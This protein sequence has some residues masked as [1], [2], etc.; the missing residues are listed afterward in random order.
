M[1]ATNP[2]PREGPARTSAPP[3]RPPSAPS[4]PPAEGSGLVTVLARPQFTLLVFGQTISQLGDKLHQMALI[5]LVG[6]EA[7]VKTSGFAYGQLA[8]V[9]V[10]LPMLFG[11]VAGALVDRWNKRITMIACDVLRVLI[12]ALIPWL[13]RQSGHLWPVYI[14]AFFVFLSGVF[15]NS[16]KMALIPDLVRRDQLLSANAA[17]TSIGRFATVA[18]LVGGGVIIGWTIWQRVG[19]TGYEAGF[20]MD[21]ISYAVSVISL[22]LITLISAAH[23][24][25]EARH[26]TTSETAV[27]VKREFQH[28][29]GDVR[30]TWKLIRTHHDLRFVFATVVLLGALAASIYVIFTASVQSVLQQGTRGVGYLGGLAAAGMVPGSLVVGTFG[31]RWNKRHI[32]L[33]GCLVVGALMIIGSAHFSFAMFAPIAFIGGFVLAPVMVSQDT[34]LHEAAP[35][36]SRALIFSTRDLI[37]GVTFGT[38]ALLVGGGISVLGYVGVSSPYRLALS[39][40]GILICAAAVSGEAAILRHRRA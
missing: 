15:F 2:A 34:L 37:V 33:A 7:E 29:A 27:L 23:A 16:A 24:R 36:G 12:V 35:Q 10:M 11:P 8:V 17:L 6:A 20:Y 39:I 21:S 32:V 40:M 1:T 25:K 4:T 3:E 18:G 28:L 13:Y 38:T 9:M 31:S 26:L 22:V 14:V 19:W 30:E 5:A